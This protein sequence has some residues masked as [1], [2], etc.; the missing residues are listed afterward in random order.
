[1]ED[2]GDC[3]LIKESKAGPH[4]IIRVNKELDEV[5]Q[6]LVLIHEW[7]HA[8]SWG[9]ESHRIRNHGPEWGIAMSR[10]WQALNED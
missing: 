1:M 4:F 3:S 7:A 2:H 8:L 10:V 9:S 6:V 5:A